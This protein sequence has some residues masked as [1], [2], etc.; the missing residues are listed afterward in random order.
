MQSSANLLSEKF[1]AQ[2]AELLRL[3]DAIDQQTEAERV[4]PL[5]EATPP[6]EDYSDLMPNPP[7]DPTA[8]RG[9]VLRRF[10]NANGAS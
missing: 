3:A 4:H 8:W 7:A 1:R 9:A 6:K 10:R 5:V 2:S